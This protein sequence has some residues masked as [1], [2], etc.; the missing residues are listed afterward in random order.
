MFFELRDFFVNTLKNLKGSARRTFCAELAI[1][2]GWG[3]SSLIEKE[4]GISSKTLRK[5]IR[6]V[7]AGVV[8]IDAY[9][10][11]HR[12]RIEEKIPNLLKDIQSILDSQSQS[13]PRFKTERLYTR[14]SVK[15]L[16]KQL[17]KQKG[18]SEE[19]LPTN[20]TLD[21][22]AIQLGYTLKKV[23]KSQPLKKIPE[24]DAIF[25]QVHRVNREADLRKDVVRISM[26]AKASV[27]L[28]ELSRD[29]KNRIEIKASD[30]DFSKKMM[31]PF[32]F[33]YPEFGETSIYF[34]TSKVTADFIV[35]CLI[36]E[37]E[38]RTLT[39]C[40]NSPGM[41]VINA[42]N[43]PENNSYRTQFIKRMVEFSAKYNIYV[44]LA[45]YPPYHSKYNPVERVWAALEQHWNGDL[46]ECEETVLK[47][48]ETMTYCSKHPKVTMV[49]K[50]YHI[51]CKVSKKIMKIYETALERHDTLE[52]WFVDISPDKSKYA[53]D[54][55]I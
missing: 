7:K 29:G 10:Q 12:K 39:L 41:L 49:N 45:Y 23:K 48:A 52:A 9:Q 30:H 18:Y 38:T 47:F 27:K 33:Y 21:T 51:G 44:R 34:T 4:L 31:T 5:G 6:E 24:T 28:G 17:I 25:K 32:G 2:L 40:P 14:L 35:D 3:G 50:V 20:R 15:E 16:R 42:D 22:K 55:L 11:R 8:C 13:D 53:L 19:E 36:E 37:W 54:L 1:K 43:G 26:D 46:L